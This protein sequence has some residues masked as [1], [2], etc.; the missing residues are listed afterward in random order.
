MIKHTASF[1][2]SVTTTGK[3][4]AFRL[5]KAFF[6]AHPEFAQR[7]R[8]RAQIV[9][10]GHV[11]VSVADP[12][13]ETPDAVDP[14]VTA[15]LSALQADMIERPRQLS[16]FTA[17]EVAAVLDLVGGVKVSDSEVLPDDVTF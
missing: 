17:A 2:G 12:S 11:L 7:A 15:Y 5:D 3:S 13:D 16:P 6:R 1:G 4:E 9:S 8:V 10:V 14:V